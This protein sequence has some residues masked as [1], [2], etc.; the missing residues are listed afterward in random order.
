MVNGLSVVH[1]SQG[2]EHFGL[3]VDIHRPA[4]RLDLPTYSLLH[5]WQCYHLSKI[6]P[7]S[8]VSSNQRRLSWAQLPAS[9]FRCQGQIPSKQPTAAGAFPQG[10]IGCDDTQICCPLNHIGFEFCEACC[11]PD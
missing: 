4:M 1:A 8:A 10:S 11:Q 6:H 9:S 3:Y 2:P 7:S 5:L